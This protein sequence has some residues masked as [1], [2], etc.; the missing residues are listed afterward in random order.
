MM[1]IKTVLSVILLLSITG[2]EKMEE[3]RRQ[4]AEDVFNEVLSEKSI[5]ALQKYERENPESIYLDRIPD[6]IELLIEEGKS[7]VHKRKTQNS[8]FY[9]FVEEL[10]NIQ[11][12]NNSTEIIVW[13]HP[14]TTERI[15]LIDKII[16]ESTSEDDVYY[17][18]IVPLAPSFTDNF[19]ESNEKRL[20]RNLRTI[21]NILVPHNLI[22][23][24]HGGVIPEGKSI[25]SITNPI[26]EVKYNIVPGSVYSTTSSDKYFLGI[27]LSYEIN[28]FI[29]GSDTTF[30]MNISIEPPAEFKSKHLGDST[31]YSNMMYE[32]FKELPV[33]VYESIRGEE[34]DISTRID[35]MS[36]SVDS[37]LDVRN[38]YK[39][40]RW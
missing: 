16:S 12:D 7:Q 4:R 11:K 9:S 2:C 26:I 31:V 32:A 1:K 24:R 25:D 40:S 15:E 10:L 21:F 35:I 6:E 27:K 29:P 13:Y 20:S 5:T 17:N 36:E 30:S 19:I 33:D 38:D 34:A 8:E 18:K 14:V 3:K 28:M 22:T 39:S 23:V 37:F